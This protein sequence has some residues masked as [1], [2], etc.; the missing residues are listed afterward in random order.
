[1]LIS[2]IYQDNKMGMVD[3]FRLDGLIASNRI[4]LFLRSEGWVRI[5]DGAVIRRN[6]DDYKGLERRRNIIK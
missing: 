3:D 4:K 1:M 6:G 5:S 2:V